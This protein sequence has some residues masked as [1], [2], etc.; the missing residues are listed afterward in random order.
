MNERIPFN[1]PYIG[2]KDH[3]YITDALSLKELS[4]DG[5]YTKKCTLWLEKNINCK[6][7]LI[8]NSCTASLEMAAL[9]I[10][11]NPGDEIIMPS[12]TFVSTA[13]AFTLRGAIPVF[14]DIRDDNLNLDENLIEGSITEKTKAIVPVHYAGVGC[15]MKKICD[16][17]EKY[18]L[19]VIEDA[20]QGI[21]STYDSK[22][23]GTIGDLG[24]FSFHATK[25][26]ISG[27][28]GALL[29]NKETYVERAE[30]IREKGTNRSNFLRG[31]SDKYTWV[32]LGSSY[33]PSEIT[34]AFLLSQL[35]EAKFITQKRLSIWNKYFINFK[36]LE[37][38]GYIKLP[39]IPKNCIHNGHMFFLL[40]ENIE[41]RNRFIRKMNEVNIQC[42]FH[43]V[44]LHESPM[45]KNKINHNREIYLPNTENLSRRLVRLP[46]FLGVE[47]YQD[48]I[49]EQ[50]LDYFKKL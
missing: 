31:Q 5:N 34:A 7:A 27:E 45:Y 12:Y 47:I 1:R 25:N 44:P 22:N 4:G 36:N 43:Y 38:A 11:I 3:K 41:E 17:A 2:S 50:I 48:Y 39:K 14:V 15:D 8:T 13:N 6:K 26:I 30:V 24:C 29:V 20:A 9:L 40:L 35:E 49:I 21:I 16:L 37:E 19:K 42:T 46:L 28:G 32:D 10:G 33:L 23:L 18:N